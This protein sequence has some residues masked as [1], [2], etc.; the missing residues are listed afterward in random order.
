MESGS[1][2]VC[3]YCQAEKPWIWTGKR[4]RDG[5][6]IYADDAGTRWAGRRCPACERSRVYA[7]V[8]CDGF[9]RDI[10]TK[11]LASAGFVVTSRTLPLKATKDGKEY[12]IGVKRACTEGG[13]I[14]LET[15]LDQG[16]DLVALVF[17]S[18]RLATTEQL[19]KMD[20]VS[21]ERCPSAQTDRSPLDNPACS[22]S[23]AIPSAPSRSESSGALPA[24]GS[25][26]PAS[27][28]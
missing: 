9:E 6:K 12:T 19:A 17:E 18:V 24:P 28:R 8:R 2:R 25:G 11:Q 14:V 23:P 20:L 26:L 4:L 5:S 16:C 7:A 22:E 3:A 1:M 27:H 15:P 13:K 10:I 21:A